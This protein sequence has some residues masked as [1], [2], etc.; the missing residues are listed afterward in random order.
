MTTCGEVTYERTYFQS[1]ETGEYEYLADKAVG[2]TPKMRKSD[3]VVIK[4][5]KQVIDVSYRI[6]GEHATNTEDIVSKQAI[7][8]EVHKLEIPTIIPKVEKK[9]QQRVLCINADEDHVSLQFHKKKRDIEKNSQ[10]MKYN[11]IMPQLIYIF[12]DIEKE[13]PNRKRKKLINKHCFGGVYAD[14]AALWEEVRTYIDAIYEYEALKKIYIM[15]DGAAW[16]KTGVELGEKCTLV[17]DAFHLK[18]YITRATNHLLDS[19]EIR[20]AMDQRIRKKREQYTDVWNHQ[21]VASR[22]WKKNRS[23]PRNNSI[24][25]YLR[26]EFGEANHLQ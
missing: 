2:I 15:G 25:R 23:I 26:I 17:L 8:K 24:K 14:N 4:A 12:E 19:V 20:E 21:S 22:Y 5:I 6:S 9:K 3:D 7:M 13:G 18:Q 16:I 1:K 11:T 10:G